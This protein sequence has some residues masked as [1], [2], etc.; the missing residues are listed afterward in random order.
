MSGGQDAEMTDL[1]NPGPP[2]EEYEE[3]REQVRCV[4]STMRVLI[5]CPN[6]VRI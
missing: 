2:G 4:R 1:K 5:S 6:K 3:I